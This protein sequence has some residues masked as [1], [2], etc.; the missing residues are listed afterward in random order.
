[1]ITG[2]AGITL[3]A[4]AFYLIGVGLREIFDPHELVV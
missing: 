2:S 1:M 3:L 4:G